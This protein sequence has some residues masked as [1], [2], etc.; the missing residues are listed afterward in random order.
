MASQLD[1]IENTVND[2]SHNLGETPAP[3]TRSRSSSTS[4]TE[5]ARPVTPPA[6][7]VPQSITDRL[8]DMQH[9]LGELLGQTQSL[10]DEVH[11]RRSYDLEIPD[12]GQKRMEDIMRRILAK[13]GD[14][15]IFDEPF[16]EEPYKPKPKKASTI[17]ESESESAYGGTNTMYSGEYSNKIPAPPNSE[18]TE[19][20][21]K[22]ENRFSGVPESLLDGSIPGSEFDED[23]AMQDLPPADP[24][25]EHV[26]PRMQIPAHL[27]KRR[28]QSAATTPVLRHSP[29]PE[30][31]EDLE[32]YPESYVSE[33]D[34][35]QAY[36][37]TEPEEEDLAPM[38]YRQEDEYER[39]P[40][41]YSEDYSPRGPTRQLPPPQPV[42]L[43]TPVNS[44]KNMPYNPTSYPGRPPFQ[45]G[46]PVPPGPTD[47]PPRPSLPRIAGVRDPISTT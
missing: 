22:R 34:D 14:E 31:P 32:E 17:S 45:G 33:Q 30:E 1:R 24:P 21:R 18:T 28:Q 42:D 44:L 13:L 16:Q 12:S 43:P 23:F 5:T 11:R 6:F 37:E 7:I 29:I 25:Q 41:V 8:D 10:M 19:Y 15:R 46:M 38:P 47:M 4:S 2:I 40:S 20:R 26:L 35:R 27:I 3:K 39:D 36:V 9:V